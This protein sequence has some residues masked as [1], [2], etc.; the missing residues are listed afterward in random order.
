MAAAGTPVQM[1][2]N[3]GS[4][5]RESKAPVRNRKPWFIP[6]IAIV[7]IASLPGEAKSADRVLELMQL[8]GLDKTFD[9]VGPGI[10]LGMKQALP[11]APMSAAF[12]DKVLAGME[13]ATEAAFAPETL[14]RE[15][16]LAMDGKL[17]NTDLDRLFAFH[18]SPLGARMTAIEKESQG[19]NAQ[20]KLAQMAATLLQG[21]KDDPKRA[22]VLTQMDSSLRL[23]EMAVDIA[24][25][26]GRAVAVGMAAADERMAALPDEA[27]AAIDAALEKMRPSMTAQLKEQ[28]LLSLAYTYR[29]ASIPELRE[30]MTFLTSPLGK[31]YYAAVV[32]AMNKVLVKAGGEFGHALM[33]ELGK[34]RT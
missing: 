14:K 19:A 11:A 24:F 10:K 8:T 18:K 3:G 5:M 29:D 9:Q 17:S 22:E 7:F 15:F 16:R 34:E 32:P 20:G 26:T 25:N 27:V 6:A 13:P 2:S 21:L 12:R 28:I 1:H 23:T 33:R 31:K 30:Y 4:P